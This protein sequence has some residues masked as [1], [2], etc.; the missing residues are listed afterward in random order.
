ML[1]KRLGRD[2]TPQEVANA[3]STEQFRAGVDEILRACDEGQAVCFSRSPFGAKHNY[4]DPGG[5]CLV[6]EVRRLRC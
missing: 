1:R 2:P 6:H 4:Q 3:L 5:L